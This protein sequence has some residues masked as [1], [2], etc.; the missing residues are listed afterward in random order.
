M[1][2]VSSYYQSA[3][4][5]MEYDLER[6][7]NF[8]KKCNEFGNHKSISANDLNHHDVQLLCFQF[9]SEII[10]IVKQKRNQLIEE[11]KSLTRD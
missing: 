1:S 4:E 2:K 5:D 6:V 9:S 8:L 3:K 7:E 10:D 11:I